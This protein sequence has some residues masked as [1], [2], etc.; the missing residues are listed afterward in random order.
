MIEGALEANVQQLRLAIEEYCSRRRA[1][2]QGGLEVKGP[3]A[4]DRLQ[5]QNLQKPGCYV[6]YLDDG[7]RKYTGMSTVAIGNRIYSHLTE[8]VQASPFWRNGRPPSHFCFIVTSSEEAPVLEAFLM[9]KG[10]Y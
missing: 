9:E 10:L 2:S 1:G 5:D 7:T 6:I 8:K 4:I 3:F